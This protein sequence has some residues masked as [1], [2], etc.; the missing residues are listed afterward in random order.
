MLPMVASG[1][2][3]I[4]FIRVQAR[5]AKAAG[6]SAAAAGDRTLSDARRLARIVAAAARHGPYRAPCLPTSLTLWWLLRRD[7]FPADLRIG[8]NKAAG[9]LEGHAW[10]EFRGRPL[11]DADDVPTRFATLEQAVPRTAA[12]SR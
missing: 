12:K 6:N 2:R 8:V 10:V 4:G 11:I 5:L 9:R 3:L 1:L 7:G